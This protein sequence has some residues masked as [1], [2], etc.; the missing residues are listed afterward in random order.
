MTLMDE[1]VRRGEIYAGGAA[2][3]EAFTDTRRV[4]VRADLAPYPF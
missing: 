2:N 4:T 3:L 1:P